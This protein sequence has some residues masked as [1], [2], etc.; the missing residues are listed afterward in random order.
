MSIA[1]EIACGSRENRTAT[2]LD[3]ELN[4]EFSSDDSASSAGVDEEE[5]PPQIRI[6]TT[7]QAE[8]HKAVNSSITSLFK[9]SMFI[10][11]PVPRGKYKSSEHLFPIDPSFDIDRV[12]QKFPDVRQRPWL[13]ERLGRAIT[14]RREYLRY[15][16]EHHHK[17]A[18]VGDSGKQDIVD[19]EEQTAP[20]TEPTTFVP[21]PDT[22]I[23]QISDLNHD[24]IFERASEASLTSF[25]TSL[26]A[27]SDAQKL[28]VP[29]PPK[30][31]SNGMVF[32]YGEPFEC[33]YCYTIHIVN[34]YRDWK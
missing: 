21:D 20:S 15:R 13:A 1:S 24:E 30:I 23:H 9:F 14:R 4:V 5:S 18:S 11:N 27:D 33:P 19:E 7:E 6:F 8:L 26:S 3:D 29:K 2:N 32:K 25:A 28:R 16:Q 10:R 22:T 17:L 12:W 31:C 34:D